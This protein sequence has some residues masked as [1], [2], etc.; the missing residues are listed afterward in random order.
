MTVPDVMTLT[1]AS[2]ARVRTWLSDREIIGTRRGPNGALMVPAAFLTG[3]GPLKSL[4]GTISVLSD[5]G[6]SDEQ[7]L[8]WLG[9]PDDTL[10]VGTPIGALQAGHKA[11]IRRRAQETAF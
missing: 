10:P 8:Q 11:E 5:S 9:E 4:R 7:I 3:E 6:L 1:G 2:Q